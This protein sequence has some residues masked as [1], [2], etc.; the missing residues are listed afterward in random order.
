MS[1]PVFS[2]HQSAPAL[3]ER[4][5]FVLVSP[6]HPGNIG[7]CARA[8]R[9][10]GLSRLALVNPECTDPASHP[11]ALARASG[12]V[13][14]LQ[15]CTV[16]A[17]LDEALREVSLAVAVSADAREFAASPV[18]PEQACA[19]AALELGQDP[20]HRVAFV[21]GP[22]RTGLSIEDAR[23][24]QMLCSIPGDPDYHSLNLSHAV[25]ILTYVLASHLRAERWRLEGAPRAPARFAMDAQVQ[26]LMAHFERA[27]TAIGF[28]DPA[29]PKKLMARLQR[30][31]ARTRLEH[32]EVELLRGIC[33]LMER[34]AG[35]AGKPPAP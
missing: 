7:A 10:M 8:M 34:V 31:F 30:L 1:R 23:R 17:N 22:E 2:L 12:A 20:T 4:V 29:H 15:E 27:L 25:Q 11:E 6:S 3:L 13:Q 35:R 21:F 18:P 9:T 33:T 24:C 16:Y 14:V 32:E 28:L 5:D 19:Q 26:A